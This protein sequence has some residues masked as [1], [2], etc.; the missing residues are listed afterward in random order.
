MFPKVCEIKMDMRQWSSCGNEI[1]EEMSVKMHEKFDKYWF[2]VQGL[3]GIA[4]LLD[5]RFKT[6]MLLVCFEMLMGIS[7][8]ECED[9]VREVTKLLCELMN[10]YQLQDDEGNTEPSTSMQSIE[11]P[12]V[13]SLFDYVP[14]TKENFNVLDWWKAAGTRYPTLRMIARDIYVILVSTVASE[15][16][17]STSGRVLS[18]HRSRLTPGM[19]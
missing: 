11:A 3:M 9:H 8:D 7:G 5:P 17:F 10:E 16:A 6:E 19:L 13:M 4:T 2:D 15:S 18:E 14:A 1:I 12:A